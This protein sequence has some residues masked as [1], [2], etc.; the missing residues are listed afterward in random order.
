MALTGDNLDLLH[1]HYKDSFSLIRSREDQ[2]DKLFLW[3]LLAYLLMI[4][5]I[6]Y[7]AN[8]HGALGSLSLLGNTVNLQHV[9]LSLV[10]DASWV[11]IAAF[12]LKYYQIV[13]YVD[14]QYDYLHMLEDRISDLLKDKDVY[15]REGQAYLSQYPRLLTWAWISYT[16]LF[17]TAL[18]LG[19]IYLYCVEAVALP[20]SWLSKV[21]DALFALS[22]I[23]TVGLYRFFPGSRTSP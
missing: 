2:R 7:P 23:V 19:T 16:Y 8:V 21:F 6:Q 14:R 5:Q 13:K 10:L 12:V 4:L 17:P 20:Y 15:R 9:P 11:F 18:I 1:D 22:V 3:L